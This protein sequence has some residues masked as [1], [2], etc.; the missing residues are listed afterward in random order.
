M[1]KYA[2]ICL[3]KIK[4][5]QQQQSLIFEMAIFNNLMTT[6]E[7]FKTFKADG[8]AKCSICGLTF[9]SSDARNKHIARVH[10]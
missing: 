5:Q 2:Y 9:G 3:K 6:F 4:K 8:G 7:T 10:S 1:Y